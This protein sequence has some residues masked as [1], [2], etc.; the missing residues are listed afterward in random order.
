MGLLTLP[1]EIPEMS[2]L[3][4]ELTHFSLKDN[5]VFCGLRRDNRVISLPL[6]TYSVWTIKTSDVN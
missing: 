1:D 4:F 3:L 2:S 6:D 5:G